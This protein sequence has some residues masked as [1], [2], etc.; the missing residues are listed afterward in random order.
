M[1]RRTSFGRKTVR[2]TSQSMPIQ[3]PR[4]KTL[5]DFDF[6]AVG[7]GNVNGVEDF[8]DLQRFFRRDQRRFAVEDATYEMV[9]AIFAIRKF[10]LDQLDHFVTERAIP[11]NVRR[12]ET[13]ASIG[14]QQINAVLASPYRVMA[15]P[16]GFQDDGLAAL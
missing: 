2:H 8:L 16:R 13:Q 9:D 10:G 3:Q 1:D 7:G 4:V 12:E 11:A 6:F 5:G 15:R 14:A